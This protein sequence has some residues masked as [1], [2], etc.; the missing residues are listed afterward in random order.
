[1]IVK[2]IEAVGMPV[3]APGSVVASS[4]WCGP[5]AVRCGLSS[6]ADQDD[7]VAACGADEFIDVP[8]DLAFGPVADRQGGEHNAQ[9]GF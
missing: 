8:T 5:V 1:M 4:F 2:S 6:S 3:G 9:A 7:V